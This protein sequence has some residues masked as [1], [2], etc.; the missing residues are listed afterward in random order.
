MFEA[1][2][3]AIESQDQ[4]GQRGTIEIAIPLCKFIRTTF[5]PDSCHRVIRTL[6]PVEFYSELYKWYDPCCS[7]TYEYFPF[8]SV[9]VCD[10]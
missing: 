1:D 9:S 2:S 5:E 3:E 7:V 4:R 6:E 10:C 8:L